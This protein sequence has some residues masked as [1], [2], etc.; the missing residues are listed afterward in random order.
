MSMV[1]KVI[2]LWYDLDTS[3]IFF[4]F[5]LMG[6][7]NLKSLRQ[8]LMLL[9]PIFH[10]RMSKEKSIPFLDF[11][12]ALYNGRLE[13]T[14]H[15][16]PTDRHQYLHYSSS[17]PEHSKRSIVFSQTLRVSI[18]CSRE[19]DFQD[20]CLQRRSWFL[21]RKYPEKP[22]DNEMKNLRF[23]PA[24][25]QNKKFEKGVPFVVTYH[26]ILNSLSKIIRDNIYLL[27]INEEVRKT[28]SSG[29]IVSFQS[30]RKLGL[31][32]V[33]TKLYPLQRKVCSSKCGE[34]RCDIFNNVTDT[35][36]FS[37]AVTGDT[38]KINHSLNCDDKCLI[39]LM[40]CKQCNKQY[41]GETTVLFHNRWNNYKD[42][43]RKFDRKESC[44]QEHLYKHFQTEGHKGSLNEASVTFID[45]TDGKDLKKTERYWM[46][47]LKTVEPYG[48]NIANSV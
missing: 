23:F 11:D 14:V 42:N 40:T 2:N 39:Y 8:I 18:I 35:S 34:R 30:A 21:K 24:N 48:L 46:R 25:L 16:K 45:K 7:K 17:H 5:G 44:M 36:T 9:I 6:K 3:M 19:K 27:N 31:Y 4:L 1:T 10:L 29:P 22:I 20:H 38:F 41:T 43:A 37:S 32:L 47:T 15:V 26:P 12:V 33:C 13:S 28:F